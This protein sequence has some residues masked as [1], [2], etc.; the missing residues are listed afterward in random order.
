[1]YG[2]ALHLLASFQQGQQAPR[3]RLKVEA[4]GI[5][6]AHPIPQ[7][8]AQ[9]MTSTVWIAGRLTCNTWPLIFPFVGHDTANVR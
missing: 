2:T 4:P 6:P 7:C 5:K 1:M 3:S 8:G 9:K